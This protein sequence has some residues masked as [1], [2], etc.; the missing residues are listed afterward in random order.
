MNTNQMNHSE[1]ESSDFPQSSDNLHF[2][3]KKLYLNIIQKCYHIPP[4]KD[5][6]IKYFT[7][8]LLNRLSISLI[9]NEQVLLLRILSLFYMSIKNTKSKYSNKI[10]TTIQQIYN[11][12][13]L[14]SLTTQGY[15][16]LLL[17]TN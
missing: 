1:E 11:S 14:V 13:N 17:N 12:G 6:I 15:I 4:Q 10:L 3:I 2:L 9:S 8:V 16:D 7:N 5:L